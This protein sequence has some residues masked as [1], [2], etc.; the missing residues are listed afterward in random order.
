MEWIVFSRNV[1]K[2]AEI[3]ARFSALSNGTERGRNFAKLPGRSVRCLNPAQA[4]AQV[5]SQQEAGKEETSQ[6]TANSKPQPKTHYQPTSSPKHWS[7]PVEQALIVNPSEH[8]TQYVNP[9]ERSVSAR[10]SPRRRG[11]LCAPTPHEALP[12]LLAHSG[13]GPVLQ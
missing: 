13:S 9:T 2:V 6:Q 4:Q 8:S 11:P 7:H 10:T 1:W 5:I 12:Q 3:T